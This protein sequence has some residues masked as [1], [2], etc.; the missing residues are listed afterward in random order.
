VNP[1]TRK[2]NVLIVNSSLCL[3]GAEMVISNLCR[4]IRRDLFDVSVC[5]LKERGN[6]GEEL[7]LLGFNVV[8]V[9]GS[10]ST[11]PDY[12]SFLKLRRIIRQYRID[13]V[14]SHNTYSL[15]DSCLCRVTVPGIKLVHTFHFGN[16]PHLTKKYRMVER[17]LW[18][19]PD[20]LVAVGIEQKKTL[21][22]TYSIPEHR[23]TT[24]WNGI[25]RIRQD[26]D[27]E[28][29]RR[30]RIEDRII[31]GTI[32]NLIEQKGY[33]YLLEVASAIRKRR[34]DVAFLVI[35]SGHL[36]GELEERSRSMGL[37]DT[38]HFLGPVANAANR[39]LPVFDIFFLP[40]LWEAMSIV[41]LEAMAIGKPILTT[42]V[43]ENANLIEDGC[44]G[45]L[46]E[47]RDVAGMTEK[48]EALIGSPEL[49]MM[50]GKAGR[51][52]IER[53]CTA[54][55]MSRQYEQLYQ[56]LFSATR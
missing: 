39:A 53:T 7:A 31:V 9:S 18:R 17:A 40:S 6:I 5:H 55:G 25:D 52:R 36:Q 44:T 54:E 24:I 14:H 45:M 2:I 28:I 49:R 1:D 56:G 23:I 34:S 48:L 26:P 10:A 19:I 4:H 11:K 35:G 29:V 41:V 12:L 15:I 32:G 3:G 51:E 38:V 43:G 47:P 27:L 50:L 22:G 42:R 16:Y 30:F 33:A 21:L 20:R 37:E 8:G 13:I 46:V